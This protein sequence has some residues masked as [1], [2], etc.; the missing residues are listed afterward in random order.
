MKLSNKKSETILSWL[1]KSDIMEIAGILG[2]SRAYV[3]KVLHGE[4][5]INTPASEEI[6]RVALRRARQNKHFRTIK[7][8]A[9]YE[10]DR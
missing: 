8:V 9:Y 7:V 10:A 3:Y 2:Y 1:T 5:E 6:L 4:R